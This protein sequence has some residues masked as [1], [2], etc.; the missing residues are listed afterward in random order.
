[1]PICLVRAAAPP[2]GTQ[3]FNITKLG[4]FFFFGE[5]WHYNNPKKIQ[6]K[7]YKGSYFGGK[8]APKLPHFQGKINSEVAKF[9]Q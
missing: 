2:P 3:F 8:Y 4:I 7:G 1:M 9:I 5:I 6:C